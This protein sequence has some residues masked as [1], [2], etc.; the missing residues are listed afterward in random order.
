MRRMFIDSWLQHILQ[1]ANDP[2]KFTLYEAYI[3]EEAAAEHKNTEHYQKW[4]DTV[5]DWMA[6]PR[7][8]VKHK[9]LFPENF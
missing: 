6:K 8:G 2:Y 9:I 1:D 3:S 4:R 5:K 7:E